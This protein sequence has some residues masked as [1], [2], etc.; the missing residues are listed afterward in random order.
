MLADVVAEVLQFL[1]RR[2]LDQ[3][4]ARCDY[5]SELCRVSPTFST[6]SGYGSVGQRAYADRC[7]R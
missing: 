2:E 7:D 3:Q 1:T 4:V 5:R 6:E